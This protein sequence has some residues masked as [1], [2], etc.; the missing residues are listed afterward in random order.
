MSTKASAR[1]RLL[2]AADELFYAEGVHI[3]G[4]D[5]IIERA[6]VAKASL[7]NAFGSKDELVRAYLQGRD[8]A[9]RARVSHHLDQY[10][11]PRDRLLSLFEVQEA[12][13]SQA[14]YHGCAFS[15]A[16]AESPG[17]GVLDAVR[18]YR[19]WLRGLM[20]DLARDAGAADAEELAREIHLVWDGAQQEFRIDRDPSVAQAARRTA[21]RLLDAALVPATR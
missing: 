4:I 6:G 21:A 2:A 18:A 11:D 14:G 17:E 16:I 3:I 1:E 20:T 19:H 8:T 9:M 7:Y 15:S 10:T 5:R 13:L 12:L